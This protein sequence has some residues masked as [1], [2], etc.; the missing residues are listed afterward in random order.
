ME[1]RGEHHIQ[2]GD[3]ICRQD[4][5]VFYRRNLLTILWNAR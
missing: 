5:R 3:T 4:G 1:R 2:Q